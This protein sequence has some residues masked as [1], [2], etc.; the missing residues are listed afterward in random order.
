MTVSVAVP[1]ST[2]PAASVRVGSQGMVKVSGVRLY[3]V[4]SSPRATMT[5]PVSAAAKQEKAVLVI[6]RT[7]VPVNFFIND[8]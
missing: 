2:V 3:R 4:L 1:Y 6:G 7:S 8:H 5:S